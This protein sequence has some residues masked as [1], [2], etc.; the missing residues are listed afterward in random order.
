M[1]RPIKHVPLRTC[2]ICRDKSE[3]RRLTRLV[4]TPEGVFVDPTGKQ[5]GRGA[6]LCDSPACLERAI[7]TDLL[8]KA[9]RTPLTVADRERIRVLAS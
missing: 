7:T 4:S 9:L 8:S 6:Y 5:A 3:K 2:V 1:S